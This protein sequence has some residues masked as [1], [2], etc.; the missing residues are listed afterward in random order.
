MH[1][2]I[3]EGNGNPLKYSCLE[4]PRKR[5]AWCVAIYGVTQIGHD[6]SDLAA[7]AS[8]TLQCCV[9]FI[10]QQSESAICIPLCIHISPFGFP[11]HLGHHIALSRVLHQGAFLELYNRFSLVIYFLYS[12]S[13]VYMSTP[14]SQFIAPL[15]RSLLI[16]IHFSLHLYLISAFQVRPSNHFLT[17][18]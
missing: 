9:V 10:I 2:C 6:L 17:F 14:I 11:F 8:F 16:S 7:A 1:A 18:H 13:N 15:P 3:G 4:N 5:G 12:V